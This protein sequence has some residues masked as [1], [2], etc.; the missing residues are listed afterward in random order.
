MET[1]E[2]RI[3]AVKR[4]GV[5][6]VAIYRRVLANAIDAK[7]IGTYAVVSAIFHRENT[8]SVYTGIVS[9]QV[10]IVADDR[11]KHTGSA[12]GAIIIRARILV[13]ARERC[14]SAN[15]I[16]A[17]IPSTWKTV[18]ATQLTVKT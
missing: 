18:L 14:M 17:D 16:D 1:S 9:A 12:K 10:I 2:N 8:P 4:T 5:V 15:A 11:S 13:V 3:A 7:I 6:V